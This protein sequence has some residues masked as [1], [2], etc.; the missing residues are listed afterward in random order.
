MRH[1]SAAGSDTWAS[2]VRENRRRLQI[3]QQA[4]ADKLGVTR[5]T[6]GRWESGRFKPEDLDIT[7]A[8]IKALGIDRELGLLVAGF[9]VRATEEELPPE[10]NIVRYARSLRLDPDDAVVSAILDSPFDDDMKQRMLRYERSLIDE[11]QRQRL[12]Q[13]RIQTESY[14]RRDGGT[15]GVDQAA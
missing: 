15:G 5:E 10:P 14:Q 12:E 7:V 13:I 1:N 3:T 6:I 4:L 9:A 8:A 11:Q 2:L